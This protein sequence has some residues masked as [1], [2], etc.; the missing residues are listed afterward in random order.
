MNR[1]SI[2][3]G[4]LVL[5]LV[6][7][8]QASGLVFFHRMSAAIGLTWLAALVWARSGLNLLNASVEAATAIAQTGV[9]FTYTVTVDSWAWWP[10]PPLVLTLTGVPMA[11][12]QP[13]EFRVPLKPNEEPIW[14]VDVVYPR[15][16]IHSAPDVAITSSDPFGIFTFRRVFPQAAQVTIYPRT[17]ELPAFQWPQESAR[18]AEGQAHALRWSF[19]R[20]G[21]EVATVREAT[22]SHSL[23]RIHWPSTARIGRPMV[24][25]F[26]TSSNW[27]AWVVTDLDASAHLPDPPPGTDELA[28]TA[29]ASILRQA[30]ARGMPVGLALT[31]ERLVQSRLEP[32]PRTMDSVLQALVQTPVQPGADLAALMLNPD[33]PWGSGAYM[34]LIT[35]TRQR[36]WPWVVEQLTDAGVQVVVVLVKAPVQESGEG[37]PGAGPPLPLAALPGVPVWTVASIQE[38]AE[39][40]E[41]PAGMPVARGARL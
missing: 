27:E 33:V 6:F 39:A 7:F 34:A 22:P 30:L 17:V 5:V 10:R 35:T 28:V 14:Q 40:L 2:L 16:G 13:S 12:G 4:L 25:E 8:G 32:G 26:E 21:V 9:P 24:K 23:S 18:T 37:A 20:G 41:W 19:P 31:G 1:K 15:R 3:M 29:A 11:P 38:L 36:H